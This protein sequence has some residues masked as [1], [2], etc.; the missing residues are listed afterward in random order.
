M[1]LNPQGWIVTG[2]FDPWVLIQG[3]RADWLWFDPQVYCGLI[4]KF[5]LQIRV[6]S[7][8]V[9]CV[10]GL[11]FDP[12]VTAG[13]FGLIRKFCGWVWPNP[14]GPQGEE[15]RRVFYRIS[16]L[17]GF[18]CVAR[19]GF[20]SWVVSYQLQGGLE[21]GEWRRWRCLTSISSMGTMTSDCKVWRRGSS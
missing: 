8:K 16:R 21:T 10:A 2:W 13:L 9:L 12:Q 4:H 1:F 6:C 7:N 5:L 19:Q 14:Q 18:S 20:V 11:L 15:R 3:L 17:I